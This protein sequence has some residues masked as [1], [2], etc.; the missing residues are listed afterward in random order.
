[1]LEGDF[2]SCTAKV[3][4]AASDALNP[5]WTFSR[6]RAIESVYLPQSAR[7][8]ILVQYSD[9]EVSSSD[10]WQDLQVDGMSVQRHAIPE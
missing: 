1:M 9:D 2:H 5:S 7:L 3:S 4:A 10:R 6:Q 8:H